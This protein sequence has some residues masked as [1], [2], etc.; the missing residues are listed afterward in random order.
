MS[1]RRGNIDDEEGLANTIETLREL[2]DPTAVEEILHTCQHLPARHTMNALRTFRQQAERSNIPSSGGRHSNGHERRGNISSAEEELAALMQQASDIFG[3]SLDSTAFAQQF[4]RDHQGSSR[5]VTQRDFRARLAR[6]EERRGGGHRGHEYGHGGGRYGGRYGE[7]RY[8]G[9]CLCASFFAVP[10]LLF[11]VASRFPSMLD[12]RPHGSFSEYE[13]GGFR[14]GGYGSNGYNFGGYGGGPALYTTSLPG[15]DGRYN[16]DYGG[17]FGGGYEGGYDEGFLGDD[18]G[19]YGEIHD[20]IYDDILDKTYGGGHDGEFGGGYGGGLGEG[21][22]RVY[23]GVYR[24][25][26]GGGRRGY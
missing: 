26:H 15:L 23:G 17:A 8:G 13:F 2:C 22:S 3:G 18:D 20:G 25:G 4:M 24:G 5:A 11:L 12:R 1:G 7:E 6:E 10:C 14:R 16:G 21:F 9:K 19:F